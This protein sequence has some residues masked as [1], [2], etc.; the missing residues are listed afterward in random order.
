MTRSS[1]ESACKTLRWPQPVADEIR[2]RIVDEEKEAK[3]QK[4]KGE[5]KAGEKGRKE[6]E[7]K[8]APTHGLPPIYVADQGR[9]R[10]RR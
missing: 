5:Q 8:E 4:A 10:C 7:G 9:S 3:K 1:L 6:G 2:I